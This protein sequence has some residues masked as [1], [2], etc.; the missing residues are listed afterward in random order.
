VFAELT[1]WQDTDVEYMDT[2]HAAG[3]LTL[4]TLV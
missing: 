2:A 1:K 4:E 3:K